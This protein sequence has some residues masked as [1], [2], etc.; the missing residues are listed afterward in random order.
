MTAY[1]NERYGTGRSHTAR[2]YAGIMAFAAIIG[3]GLAV[4]TGV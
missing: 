2:F 4:L 3:T 1:R